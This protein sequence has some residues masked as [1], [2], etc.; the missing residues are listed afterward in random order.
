MLQP[1]A[2]SLFLWAPELMLGVG[3]ML[4]ILMGVF[5]RR[6]RAAAL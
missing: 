2:Q 3:A 1:I 6:A 4:V 5:A